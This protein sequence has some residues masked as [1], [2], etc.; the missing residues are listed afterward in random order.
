MAEARK[1][2]RTWFE[3]GYGRPKGAAEQRVE[4]IS[5]T[6]RSMASDKLKRALMQL[7]NL[8]EDGEPGRLQGPGEKTQLEDQE[9]PQ[10]HVRGDS[11]NFISK[12]LPTLPWL[13]HRLEGQALPASCAS[14]FRAGRG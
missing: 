13:V 8:A 4:Y 9:A 2:K 6:Y 10:R 7:E 12:H 14:A 11:S 5:I 3:E 1:N